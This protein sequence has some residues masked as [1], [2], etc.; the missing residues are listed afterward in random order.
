MREG[1]LPTS[2][3]IYSNQAKK[4]IGI[5]WMTDHPLNMGQCFLTKA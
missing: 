4:Q 1:N 2:G 3:A 5:S